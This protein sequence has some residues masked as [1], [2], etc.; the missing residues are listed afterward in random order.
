[1]RSKNLFSLERHLKVVQA[2]AVCRWRLVL[3]LQH[4]V[5]TEV[6]GNVEHLLAAV[7]VAAVM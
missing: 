5:I 3:C 7:P 4:V 6:K 1:M 2:A